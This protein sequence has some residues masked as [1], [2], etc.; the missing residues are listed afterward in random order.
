MR[1]GGRLPAGT[2][3]KPV[4]AEGAF[5]APGEDGEVGAGR[6]GCS[7]ERPEHSCLLPALLPFRAPPA[8]S[9]WEGGW[10]GSAAPRGP[11]RSV[12][13]KD[14]LSLHAGTPGPRLVSVT[15]PPP[16]ALPPRSTGSQVTRTKPGPQS[17]NNQAPEPDS[18]PSALPAH[19]H[20]SVG[21]DRDLR[22]PTPAP[23]RTASMPHCQ[24]QANLSAGGTTAQSGGA[25]APAWPPLP[26]Q[27]RVSCPREVFGG[28]AI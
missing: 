8:C 13:G 23:M 3:C 7:W 11:R 25:Q 9:G 15:Q 4:R 10:A 2:P 20:A 18:C 24:H 14:P 1:S 17:R 28:K 12:P 19:P 6:A 22:D 5:L 27:T 16:A 26:S 21:R